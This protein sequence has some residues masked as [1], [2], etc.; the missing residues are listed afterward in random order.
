MADNYKTHW[1]DRLESMKVKFIS[2]SSYVNKDDK[3]DV[4]SHYQINSFPGK[5]KYC[6]LRWHHNFFKVIDGL[7]NIK[8]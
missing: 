6:N 1:A 8:I 7:E 5:I 2:I 3:K 4:I